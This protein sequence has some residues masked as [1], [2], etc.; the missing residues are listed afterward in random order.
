[1]TVPDFTC[2]CLQGL[3][4]YHQYQPSRL[5]DPT[6]LTQQSHTMDAFER[7]FCIFRLPRPPGAAGGDPL[8]PYPAWKAVR[9]DLVVVPSSQFPFALLGWTGSQ[10]GCVLL[11]LPGAGI[12][13]P[14]NQSLPL[15]LRAGAAS[16]QPEGEGAVS[17]QP[18][19][20]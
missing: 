4:L 18:W 16:L 12:A 11:R 10:V 17:E 8:E 13:S 20:V 9:V 2:L 1:M 19:T 6:R 7:S 15:A 3:V 5:D 14:T